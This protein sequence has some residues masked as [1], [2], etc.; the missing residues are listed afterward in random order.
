[1][2]AKEFLKEADPYG[3]SMISP[4]DDE[5]DERSINHAYDYMQEYIQGYFQIGPGKPYLEDLADPTTDT[6]E[7]EAILHDL[8]G[9][10]IGTVRNRLEKDNM[11]FFS[12]EDI[13]REI[14][15]YLPTSH[16]TT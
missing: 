12:D 10:A 9:D 5:P 6:R 14:V 1:M 16:Q 4:Y 11:D 13:K 2:R 7:R 15:K 8:F 3:G